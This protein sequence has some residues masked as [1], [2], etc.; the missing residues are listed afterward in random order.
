MNVLKRRWHE[1]ECILQENNE[2]I[3]LVK[4]LS[5]DNTHRAVLKV[6]KKSDYV[7]FPVILYLVV[8]SII[9]FFLSFIYDSIKY[10]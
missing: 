4:Q 5:R 1:K 6:T 8:L 3:Q 2:K 7:L 9:S 10:Y